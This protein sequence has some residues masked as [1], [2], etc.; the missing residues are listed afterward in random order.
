MVIREMQFKNTMRYHLTLVRMAII[1]KPTNNK[2]WRGCGEKGSL[3]H[4]WW[5][6]KLV[7][8]FWWT[9]RRV[10]ERATNDPAIPFLGI[11]SGKTKTLI[12]KDTW[13]P[14]LIAALFIIAKTWKQS[15]FTDG[16]MDKEDVLYTY[17]GILLSHK[18]ERNNVIC[19]N[20]DRN[21]D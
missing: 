2:C 7:Q 9:T 18:K 3:W 13:T 20:M 6:W 11:Y 21:R 17:N 12:W 1:I 5:E 15:I 8:L 16:W 14:M 10:L 4:Y 19:S